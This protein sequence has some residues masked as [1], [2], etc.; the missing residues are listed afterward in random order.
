MCQSLHTGQIV[1][2]TLLLPQIMELSYKDYTEVISQL[3]LLKQSGFDIEDFGNRSICIRAVPM[4]LGTAGIQSFITDFSGCLQ[5]MHALPTDE[6]KR[7]MLIK[8][9]CKKAVKAGDKLP[10]SEIRDLIQCCLKNMAPT[11][12]HGRPIIVALE[13]TEIDKRFKRII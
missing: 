8:Y 13:K 2:Q 6:K 1:S 5:E 9:A 10:E 11:C 7:D 3:E 4:I 12:P